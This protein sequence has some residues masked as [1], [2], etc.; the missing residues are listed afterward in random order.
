MQDDK[1]LY[2]EDTGAVTLAV[3]QVRTV[4]CAAEQ[5]L[6]VVVVR[7]VRPAAGGKSVQACAACREAMV[8]TDRWRLIPRATR[9]AFDAL[10][11]R[12]RPT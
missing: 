7:I 12:G 3:C 4:Q 5:A 1:T 2:M 10:V 9:A 8:A 11:Q 6:D